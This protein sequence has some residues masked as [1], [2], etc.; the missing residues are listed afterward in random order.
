MDQNID[1]NYH[2]FTQ[3]YVGRQ[4]HR[5]PA[6]QALYLRHKALMNMLAGLQSTCSTFDNPR[7]LARTAKRLGQALALTTGA[8][9]KH[10]LDMLEWTREDVWF[11]NHRVDRIVRKAGVIKEFSL[12]FNISLAAHNYS[13]KLFADMISI[14]T[15]GLRGV[16]FRQIAES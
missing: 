6:C 9:S 16:D 1:P 13:A 14:Y 5:E 4:L 10:G 2:A 12:A 3:H 11:F 7:N 15:K 8:I